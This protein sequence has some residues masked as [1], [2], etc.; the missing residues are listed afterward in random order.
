MRR[1]TFK[2]FVVCLEVAELGIY[3]GQ[4]ESSTWRPRELM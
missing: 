4:I 1:G 2:I 3:L